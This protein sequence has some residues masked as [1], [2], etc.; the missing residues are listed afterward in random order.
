MKKI[1]IVFFIMVLAMSL[2][3]CRNMQGIQNAG[4]G[5][6]QSE[7][8][9]HITE[10]PRPKEE[11]AI[12]T[13]PASD[14]AGEKAARALEQALIQGQ[15]FQ[16]GSDSIGSGYG[17][18]YCFLEDRSYYWF[19]SEFGGTD[20]YPQN[21][22]MVFQS[23]TWRVEPTV[24]HGE[25][26]PEDYTELL[27][28]QPVVDTEVGGQDW[29][30]PMTGGWF[31]E[32]AVLNRESLKDESWME[33]SFQSGTVY[34]DGDPAYPVSILLTDNSDMY[35][36]LKN[37]AA[38]DAAMVNGGQRIGIDYV[39]DQVNAVSEP[40]QE[41]GWEGSYKASNYSQ[42]G[43]FVNGA[44]RDIGEVDGEMFRQS[45]IF[46]EEC[47][48][49]YSEYAYVAHLLAEFDGIWEFTL[50]RGTEKYPH[51]V[52]NGLR[53]M[54]EG[55]SRYTSSLFVYV[56]ETGNF[57]KYLDGVCS[58]TMGI[59]ETTGD[60][61]GE[62]WFLYHDPTGNL[63]GEGDVL[64]PLNLRTGKLEYGSS[65]DTG[66]NLLGPLE[67][68]GM[69]QYVEINAWL[70]NPSQVLELHHVTVDGNSGASEEDIWYLNTG[71][72]PLKLGRQP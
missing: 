5:K 6:G 1:G 70:G 66:M 17:E 58:E 42:L 28:T 43:D 29:Q 40:V 60:Q 26:K 57:V 45:Q 14:T 51:V 59:L 4:A 34:I 52:F 30:D 49:V 19:A 27:L 13:A 72:L 48:A 32:G 8:T 11:S 63:P 21:R 31:L 64:F 23:G 37:Y 47:T 9:E 44:I 46:G 50:T 20:R 67:K 56:K 61:D 39:Y 22:R 33:I 55:W 36:W 69:Y 62:A 12:P 41:D 15:T 53:T 2:T 54:D 71:A 25:E 38:Q 35:L 10:T 24:P 7:E 68:E 18:I 3:A 65:V 16:I